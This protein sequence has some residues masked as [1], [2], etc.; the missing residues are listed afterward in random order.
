M[1]CKH[2]AVIYDFSFS[3]FFILCLLSTLVK[4]IVKRQHAVLDLTQFP[5]SYGTDRNKVVGENLFKYIE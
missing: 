5:T 1:L 4:K 3:C 2:L